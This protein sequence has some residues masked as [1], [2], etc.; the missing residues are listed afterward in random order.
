[1]TIQG[2]TT[3]KWGRDRSARWDSH[4]ENGYRTRS[5]PHV[6]ARNPTS[7]TPVVEKA[8]LP[9]RPGFTERQMDILRWGQDISI[10]TEGWYCTIMDL[11]ERQVLFLRDTLNE[12]FGNEWVEEESH[13]R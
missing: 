6:D 1:M 2:R 10:Q 5:Y 7:M 4:A 3:P 13:P 12:W 8:T 11:N 9:G